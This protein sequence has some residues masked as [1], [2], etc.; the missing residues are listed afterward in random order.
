MR[1]AKVLKTTQRG[2]R[3]TAE[4]QNDVSSA[5]NSLSGGVS[6]IRS[7][8]RVFHEV[9]RTYTTV[10]VEITSDDATL[11]IDPLEFEQMD[12]CTLK[13]GNGQVMILVFNNPPQET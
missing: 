9:A 6:G 1:K 12:T 13:S 7:S 4:H 5:I 10:S 3:I 8:D 2:Q 11:T